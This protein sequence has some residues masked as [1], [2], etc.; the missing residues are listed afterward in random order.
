MIKEINIIRKMC[1]ESE[2]LAQLAEEA[3][4]LAIATIDYSKSYN[5]DNFIEEI[6]DVKLC[7]DVLGDYLDDEINYNTYG[8]ANSH[9]DI[10]ISACELSKAALK[11]RRA[12]LQINPTPI[13]EPEARERF[14]ETINILTHH[15]YSTG[16]IYI[17]KNKINTIYEEK[18][19][20]WVNRL[21][22]K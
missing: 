9:S 16:L 1:Q 3:S 20:R 15:I 17:A 4:E 10:I 6:A 11:L 2:L 13:S 18:A 5:I 19:I 8:R 12:I 21:N 14:I 22:N 7:I